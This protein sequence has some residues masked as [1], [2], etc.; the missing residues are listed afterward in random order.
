MVAV[1]RWR[2][3]TRVL[4]SSHE[5]RGSMNATLNTKRRRFHLHK[6]RVPQEGGNI[7]PLLGEKRH[8]K[9]KMMKSK[10]TQ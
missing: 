3:V 10:E 5:L 7:W 1:E 8:E 9:S 6:S 2:D 4:F